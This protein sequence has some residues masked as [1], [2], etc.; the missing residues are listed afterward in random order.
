M[1]YKPTKKYLNIQD[2][3]S[4]ILYTNFNICCAADIYGE[5]C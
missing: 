3:D 2:M 4:K 1:P 5:C